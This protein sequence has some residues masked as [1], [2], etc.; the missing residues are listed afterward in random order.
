MTDT[1]TRDSQTSSDAPSR[2]GLVARITGPVIAWALARR[3]VRAALLY[4]ERRGP[5]LADS[6]TYRA[7]FSVF[8]GVLL[9]FSIA[10]LWLSG[11][12]DAWR[13]IIDAVQSA[14]PGLIGEDGVIDTKDLRSPAS[15]SIAGIISLVALIGSALGAIGSL[16]TAIRVIAGTVQD[17]ILFIWVM[18][19]NLLLGLGIGVAFVLA[20]GLTFVGQL[21]ATWIADLLELPSDSPLVAWTVRLLSLLVVFALDAGLIIGAFLLLSGVRPAARSLWTGALL[22]AFGLI[23]LQQLSG[24]F[25]GGATSNPLLASFAS[26]LA[27]L[28]WL[29]LSTQ[30]ILVACAYIVTAEEE[31]TDRLH[32]RFGAR[33]FVQR[34]LQRAEVDVRIATA[35]LR[36]AQRAAAEEAH[37]S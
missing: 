7:L 4:S 20:A 27:L 24:L 37:P 28:I 6:V 35:E 33:T 9:G 36:E 3:P 10:A 26:L 32:E 34:R 25:V 11:N 15:F 21:G 13:A 17:D 5:M 8:A 1:D 29:N 16:R 14:V 12:P 18:V 31:R 22:G 23:V 30:V 2:P 19:R